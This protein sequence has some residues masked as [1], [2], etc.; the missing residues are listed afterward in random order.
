MNEFK[1]LNYLI[2]CSIVVCVHTFYI[3]FLKYNDLSNHEKSIEVNNNVYNQLRFNDETLFNQLFSK[4]RSTSCNERSGFDPTS[5]FVQF[6]REEIDSFIAMNPFKNC[7]HKFTNVVIPSWIARSTGNYHFGGFTADMGWVLIVARHVLTQGN[8][9]QGMQFQQV[10]GHGGLWTYFFEEITPTG[11]ISDDANYTQL[12]YRNE[13]DRRTAKMYSLFDS[14]N[15]FTT[16]RNERIFN[17][18]SLDATMINHDNDL[19][20]TRIMF[21]WVFQP[22]L[23]IRRVIDEKK[24][25][26]KNGKTEYIGIH[27]RRGDKTTGLGGPKESVSIDVDEFIA[28]I[29]CSEYASKHI[30]TVFVSTDEYIAFEEIRDRLGDQWN[31]Y[32]TAVPNQRGFTIDSYRTNTDEYKLE[33]TIN[34]WVD[35]ELLSESSIFIGNFQ[36]NIAKTVHYMRLGHDPN[37]SINTFVTRT[38]GRSCCAKE[39]EFRKADCFRDCTS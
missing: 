5:Q 29:G 22:K 3:L 9:L 31:V 27:V 18:L 15:P 17:H 23:S 4:R 34:T 24:K 38:N 25:V 13:N 37:T 14:S 10:F 28:D 8:V 21:Q 16:K 11:C 20:A 19:Q 12:D 33:S 7:N 30:R 36:S 26:L 32:T 6:T 2:A 35:L 39:V 1:I